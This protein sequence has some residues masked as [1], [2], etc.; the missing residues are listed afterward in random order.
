[1]KKPARPASSPVEVFDNSDKLRAHLLMDLD[2]KEQARLLKVM[3]WLGY[4]A[5][6]AGFLSVQNML[7]AVGRPDRT[8]PD[9]TGPDRTGP[10]KLFDR[11]DLAHWCMQCEP[12]R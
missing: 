8:G 6:L 2:R 10:N 9:R 11:T 7:A 12:L 5:A 1:M 4:L 3:S